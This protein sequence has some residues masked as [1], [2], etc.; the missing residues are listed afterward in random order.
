[1]RGFLTAVRLGRHLRQLATL[2][3]GYRKRFVGD[4]LGNMVEDDAK[5]SRKIFQLKILN[6]MNAIMTSTK[7]QSEF[8]TLPV[9]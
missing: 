9:C 7:F 4:D 2:E 6:G 3:R 5:T 1:M 8:S